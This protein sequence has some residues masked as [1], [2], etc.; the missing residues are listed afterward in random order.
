MKEAMSP[1]ADA[2]KDMFAAK[3]A[4]SYNFATV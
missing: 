4:S 2:V 3:Y 1:I